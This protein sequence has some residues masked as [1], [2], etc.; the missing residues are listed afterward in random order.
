MH[1]HHAVCLALG[2]VCGGCVGPPPP[3]P[4]HGSDEG[5]TST[6]GG[7]PSTGVA[8]SGEPSSEGTAAASTTSDGGGTTTGDATAF[9]T[10]G[11]PVPTAHS[12]AEVHAMDP[13]ASSGVYAI[14]LARDGITVDVHCEMDVH[15]GGWTL[16]ARSAPRSEVPFGWGVEQG[17]LGDEDVPYSLGVANRGLPFTEIL[18]TRIS[19]FAMPT[20]NAYV[21]DVPAG[22]LEDYRDAAYECDG[23]LTVLGDCAPVSGPAFLRWFGYTDSVDRYFFRDFASND[24]WGLFPD[25]FRTFYDDCNQG[26]NLNGQQGALFVR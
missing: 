16:V 14:V 10:T 17:T 7:S 11:E 22:F 23:A 20:E 4:L 6:S 3:A 1:A 2:T 9:E 15:G 5:S 8:S 13:S 18:I 21:V 19:G 25:G 12:C 24:P 26:G